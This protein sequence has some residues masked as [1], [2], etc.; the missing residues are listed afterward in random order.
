MFN[1]VTLNGVMQAP[2]RLD[3]DRRAD[4]QVKIHPRL[5]LSNNGEWCAAYQPHAT[6]AGRF[7][8]SALP[9]T[10]PGHWLMPFH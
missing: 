10:A 7:F 9:T 4:R 2:A 6:P 3:E 1:N 8:R 5:G